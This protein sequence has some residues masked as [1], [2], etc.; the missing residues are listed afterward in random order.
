MKMD[1]FV[2]L[3]GGRHATV[4]VCQE[5]SIHRGES[6]KVGDMVNVDR[7]TAFAL[8]KQMYNLTA[9]GEAHRWMPKDA[10][11]TDN[12]A[13]LLNQHFQKE[14]EKDSGEKPIKVSKSK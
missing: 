13:A 5:P 8:Y 2:K 1:D 10:N 7:V 6:Y 14:H 3:I 9:G 4:M 12:E 11:I